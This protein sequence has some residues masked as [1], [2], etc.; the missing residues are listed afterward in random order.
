ME[1]SREGRKPRDIVIYD[2]RDKKVKK[3]DLFILWRRD[4]FKERE[5]EKA[6]DEIT[7]N[8]QRPL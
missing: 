2:K 6:G 4:K 3:N 5:G 1:I 7:E 8:K